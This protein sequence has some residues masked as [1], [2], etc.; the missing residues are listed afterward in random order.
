MKTSAAMLL[1]LYV[2]RIG[3]EPAVSGAQVT[4]GADRREK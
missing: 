4:G 3:R 1:L 2:F